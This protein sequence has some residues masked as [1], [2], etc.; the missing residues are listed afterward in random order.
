MQFPSSFAQNASPC[1]SH[2]PPHW[3]NIRGWSISCGK[4]PQL[5]SHAVV[6]HGVLSTGPPPPPFQRALTRLP[7][8]PP[9][10]E[11]VPLDHESTAAAAAAQQKQKQQ[12]VPAD[13]DFFTSYYIAATSPLPNTKL[14][15]LGVNHGSSTWKKK[16]AINARHQSPDSPVAKRGTWL[17]AAIRRGPPG[18][19]CS[20]NQVPRSRR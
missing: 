12:C 8:M 1:P 16:L 6:N 19:R 20:G 11:P 14:V 13:A 3:S 17:Q 9:P 2:G 7:P 18:T 15:V 10:L 4:R 5:L